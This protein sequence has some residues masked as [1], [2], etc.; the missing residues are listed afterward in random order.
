LPQS[1]GFVEIFG[2]YIPRSAVEELKEELQ[3]KT[4]SAEQDGRKTSGEAEN[5]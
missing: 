1:S 5:P 2:R 3:Q 4:E